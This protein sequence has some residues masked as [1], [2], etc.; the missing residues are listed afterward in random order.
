M[1]VGSAIRAA[2]ALVVLAATAWLLGATSDGRRKPACWVAPKTYRV[3]G[4][5]GPG[6]I[7]VFEINRDYPTYSYQPISIWNPAALGFPVTSMTSAGGRAVATARTYS[8]AVDTWDLQFG[9][10]TFD[11]GA[12][13]AVDPP[14]DGVSTDSK[15]GDTASDGVGDGVSE[16]TSESRE[17]GSDG[18]SDLAAEGGS[19]LAADS[20]SDGASESMSW[21]VQAADSGTDASADGG[22]GPCTSC[23][24]VTGDGGTTAGLF[25]ECTRGSETICRSRLTEIP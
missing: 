12:E 1:K 25:V 21:P 3:E 24:T 7:V 13:P 18:L 4:D 6:G 16:P 20:A 5:C 22:N 9:S 10:C 19:D 8:C 15:P 11:A 2:G 14:R 17:A 23:R